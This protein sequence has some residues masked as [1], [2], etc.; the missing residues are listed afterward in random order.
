[1]F[2]KR[3]FELKPASRDTVI[4]SSL[5]VVPVQED[6][7][8][9]DADGVAALPGDQVIVQ[10]VTLLWQVAQFLGKPQL[11]LRQISQ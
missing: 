3:K 11:L 2:N 7:G 10:V 8:R 9:D 5:R 6:E 1:M 4:W